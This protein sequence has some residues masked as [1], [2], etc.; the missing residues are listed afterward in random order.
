MICYAFYQRC[1]QGWSIVVAFTRIALAYHFFMSWG[2]PRIASLHRTFY[3][4]S[5]LQ[6]AA[7]TL[8]ENVMNNEQ[9][10]GKAQQV[11]GKLKEKWGKLTGDDIALY[12]G[13]R[14]HFL[15][16]LKEHYGLAKED[17]EKQVK[18]IEDACNTAKAA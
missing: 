7:L 13:K 4:R 14:E 11:T 18:A 6:L 9:L 16:K 5:T 10:Q 12:N 2:A 1:R 8:M 3:T 15:G 17:A